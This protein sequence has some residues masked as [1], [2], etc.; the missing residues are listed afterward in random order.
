M[1]TG[2]EYVTMEK[3]FAESD[4]ISLH[5][6]LMPQ[7]YHLVNEAALALMKR[8]VVLINTSRGAL[9]DASA[10][11]KALKQGRIGAAGLDVYE[12]EAGV[13]FQDLSGHVLQDD[14][15]ARLMTFPNVIITSHQAFLT[16]EALGNIAETTLGNVRGFMD[17][18]LSN[19]VK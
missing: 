8:G 3:L 13:F 19:E 1:E 5:V 16:K 18:K 12:E 7:T 2:L 17:G 10:L 11:I 14:V 15:L 9:V 4:V 6:P